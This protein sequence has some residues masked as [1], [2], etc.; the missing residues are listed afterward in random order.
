MEYPLRALHYPSRLPAAPAGSPVLFGTTSALAAASRGR[1]KRLAFVPAGFDWVTS[2]D[3]VGGCCPAL[4]W[5]LGTAAPKHWTQCRTAPPPLVQIAC[6]QHWSG[7]QD[8]SP[9]TLPSAGGGVCSTVCT[10]DG[11]LQLIRQTG[12]HERSCLWSCGCSACTLAV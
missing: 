2:T 8:Q 5:N 4:G 6:Q 10:R 1:S 12:K 11:T 3:Q 7:W 9:H